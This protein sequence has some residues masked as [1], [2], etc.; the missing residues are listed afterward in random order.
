MGFPGC[1][2]NG[3]VENIACESNQVVREEIHLK[4]TFMV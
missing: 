3:R 4:V 1:S 2:P